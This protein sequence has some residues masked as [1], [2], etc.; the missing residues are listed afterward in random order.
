[1]LVGRCVLQ[2]LWSINALFLCVTLIEGFLRISLDPIE[3]LDIG[4][5]GLWNEQVLL[6]RTSVDIR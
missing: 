4:A 3:A 1:M 2:L 5:K 6:Q